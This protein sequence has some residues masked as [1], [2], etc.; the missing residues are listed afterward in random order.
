MTVAVGRG[1]RRS[2]G[3]RARRGVCIQ[4]GLRGSG[5]GR[6]GR[7]DAARVGEAA[8]LPGPAIQ[9]RAPLGEEAAEADDVGGMVMA[10]VCVDAE[11]PGSPSQ[12]KRVAVGTA[13][14]PVRAVQPG[15]A[16]VR[17]RRHA[18][19]RAAYEHAAGRALFGVAGVGVDVLVFGTVPNL[20]SADEVTERSE[21][22][23][24]ATGGV[25]LDVW[26]P[27]GLDQHRRKDERSDSTSHCHPREWKGI[28]PD[29][30]GPRPLVVPPHRRGHLSL[31][32][33]LVSGQ[34]M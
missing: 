17:K 32:W 5:G 13:L 29:G 18:V 4:G 30:A 31:A 28:G 16:A 22:A 34:R 6:I 12:A 10:D 24:E 8:G 15:R 7:V 21:V 19:G 9:R 26:G 14:K 23:N 20:L 33:T 1:D 27:V 25:A 2:G 3:R 11:E